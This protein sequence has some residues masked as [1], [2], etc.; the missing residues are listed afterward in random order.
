MSVNV[1][2]E[3]KIMHACELG[4]TG[5]YRGHKCVARYFFRRTLGDLDHMRSHEVTHADIFMKLI[6]ERNYSPCLAYSLF[7]WGG[8]FYGVAIGILGLKAI[9]TSTYTIE[10]IVNEE[11]DASIESLVGETDIVR[12]LKEVQQDEIKHQAAGKSF[13]DKPYLL[14]SVV[15]KMARLG[16][17]SAKRLAIIL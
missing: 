15:A 6:Q 11:L 17:Y 16:A 9:G 7:F 10:S 13:A 2:T 3:L 14:E 12:V 5:V 8:L 4:A 1:A